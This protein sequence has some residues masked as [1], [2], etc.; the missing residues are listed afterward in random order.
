MWH[1]VAQLDDIV[2]GGT[3]YVRVGEEEICLCNDAGRGGNARHGGR[4]LHP[5]AFHTA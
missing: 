5:E 3:K 2:P 4:R 1:E